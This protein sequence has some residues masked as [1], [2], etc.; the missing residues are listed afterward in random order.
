MKPVALRAQSAHLHLG[1]VPLHLDRPT[2]LGKVWCCFFHQRPRRRS[3]QKYAALFV[4]LL[5]LTPTPPPRVAVTM[6]I[7]QV[8]SSLLLATSFA[9]AGSPRL[10][11]LV[12]PPAGREDLYRSAELL[13]T[14]FPP[15]ARSGFDTR[16]RTSHA[17]S[18]LGPEGFWTESYLRA[19]YIEDVP[20]RY[21]LHLY[22]HPP[23]FDV[24]LK[25]QRLIRAINMLAQST[26]VEIA[27][28]GTTKAELLDLEML[29]V[30]L[31][32]LLRQTQIA[33]ALRYANLPE[34]WRLFEESLYRYWASFVH[35]S[36]GR[37]VQVFRNGHLDQHLD[38]VR[39]L[40]F[41]PGLEEPLAS[42]GAKAKPPTRE[43]TRSKVRTPV[44]Q[45]AASTSRSWRGARRVA[46]ATNS[47]EERESLVKQ[48]HKAFEGR[49]HF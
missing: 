15:D 35:V 1:H 5:V 29:Q 16:F 25:E 13:P 6:H 7:F 28:D 14:D 22:P 24:W 32:G 19:H 38:H 21:P 43:N 45:E 33:T 30:Y 2:W 4:S 27:R 18:V 39:K 31:K 12:Q 40:A 20:R 36:Q 17:Y 47:A 26:E 34:E 49:L 42:D 10:T 23:P 46:D 3:V 48:L 41:G 11:P 9:V 44:Q 37:A 8:L